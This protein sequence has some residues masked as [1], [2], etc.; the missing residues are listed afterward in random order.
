MKIMST[1]SGLI[2][3]DDQKESVRKFTAADG[4][5]RV[6][7]FKYA[8]PFSNHFKYCHTVDDH[9]NLRHAVPSL[10]GTWWTYRWP[11]RVFLFF[12]L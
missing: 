6:V 9:N 5:E 8:E 12:L 2:E 1:Y 4:S 10:E 7:R 3:A 11:F